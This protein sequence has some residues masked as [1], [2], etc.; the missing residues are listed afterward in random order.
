MKHNIQDLK[1]IS[2]I[3][4]QISGLTDEQTQQVETQ[5]KQQ[6]QEY[7][8]KKDNGLQEQSTSQQI[9]EEETQEAPIEENIQEE[10]V[11]QEEPIE[12]SQEEIS[13][14]DANM[15]I[16]ELTNNESNDD[17]LEEATEEEDI[18]EEFVE[19]DLENITIGDVV[20]EEAT[21]SVDEF[22]ESLND[23]EEM[24][25]EDK[26]ND[27]DYFVDD[28]DEDD[29]TFDGINDSIDQLE[30]TILTAYNSTGT[31]LKDKDLMSDT[32]GNYKQEKYRPRDKPPRHDC[33]N[34]FDHDRLTKDEKKDFNDVDNDLDLKVSNK[35]RFRNQKNQNQENCDGSGD[36]QCNKRVNKNE[37]KNS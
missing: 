17:S 11:S 22:I 37:K 29:E 16:E 15:T 33:R 35:R 2:K 10:E 6:M 14:E 9:P 5:V 23:E 12:E 26:E 25:Y 1:K 32:G 4:L 3:A 18:E 21:N 34:N 19:E 20:E 36:N 28:E 27:E 31:G 30:A 8:D 24:E 13:K 7:F